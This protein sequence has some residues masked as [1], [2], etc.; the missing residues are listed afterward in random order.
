MAAET[1]NHSTQTNTIPG[2][3]R[4]VLPRPH[5]ILKSLNVGWKILGAGWL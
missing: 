5:V 4:Q 2:L 1:Q 3:H